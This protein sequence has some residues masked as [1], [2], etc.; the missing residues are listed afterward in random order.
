MQLHH[1]LKSERQEA[2]NF[3]LRRLWLLKIPILP[4]TS[5]N[6]GILSPKCCISEKKIFKLKSSDRQK[7]KRAHPP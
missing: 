3:R 4:P 1:G 5:T 6:P 2:A 7:I